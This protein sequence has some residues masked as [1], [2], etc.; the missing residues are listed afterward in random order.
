M[1]EKIDRLESF[2]GLM[3]A[4]T[5]VTDQRAHRASRNE[6]Y[7]GD[8]ESAMRYLNDATGNV[9]LESDSGSTRYVGPA[10]WES[11]IED[12]SAFDPV[13]GQMILSRKQ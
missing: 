10:N 7:T 11:I 8:P 3:Q 2:V 9:R 5:S 6:A 1:Q 4:S 13:C 12:V